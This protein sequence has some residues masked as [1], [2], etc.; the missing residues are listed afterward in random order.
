MSPD[1]VTDVCICGDVMFVTAMAM[2]F[3]PSTAKERGAM[4]H[5]EGSKA[6]HGGNPEAAAC[7]HGQLGERNEVA[8]LSSLMTGDSVVVARGRNPRALVGGAD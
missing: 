8:G 3:C 7:G 1:P 2:L 5:P 4:A 6:M